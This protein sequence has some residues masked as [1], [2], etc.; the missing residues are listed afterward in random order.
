MQ[1]WKGT[2]ATVLAGMAGGFAVGAVQAQGQTE[3]QIQERFEIAITVDD[4]T[5][6]GKLPQGMT[7]A[8]IAEAHIA[9][10]RAHGVP[11]AYGFVNAL[12]VKEDP[13]SEAVLGLWR[14]AGYPL[15]NHT[16]SHLNIDKAESL[17][18][19]E[20]DVLAGEPLVQAYM[21]AEGGYYFRFPNLAAGKE[22]AR[23][24]AAQAFLKGRHY[25]IADVSVAFADWNY[26]DA[27]ARCLARG[28]MATIEAMKGR[29]LRD[30]DA[31]IVRMKAVSQRVYGRII[32]QVLLT[33]IGGW[34]AMMLPE[35]LERL[36]AAGATY[37]TLAQAQSDPA[38]AEPGGGSVMERTAKRQGIDLSGLPQTE[39]SSEVKTYCR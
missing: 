10:F 8:G 18:A 26:T 1:H 7:R 39:S 17:E 9:A 11:E 3:G 38:Y 30:V 37:V 6:H 27:Y 28:D 19:W 25:H 15:G 22:P 21:S 2:A 36:D 31:G 14:A 24:E 13:E 4:L 29:Y 23:A 12:R 32:P 33:H 34:S 20:A 5:A 35:V 16:F